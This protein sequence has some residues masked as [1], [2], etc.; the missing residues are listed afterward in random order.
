VARYCGHVPLA[1]SRN[2][3][4]GLPTCNLFSAETGLNA[5]AHIDA[6]GIMKTSSYD[7][8]GIQILE[9]RVIAALNKL[10]IGNQEINL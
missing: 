10:A 7:V 8:K 6:S 2:G 3:A 4:D 1:V 9:N 5:F